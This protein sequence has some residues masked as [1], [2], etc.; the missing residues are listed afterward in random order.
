MS[1]L[2]YI[3]W[4]VHSMQHVCRYAWYQCSNML[5]HS[6]FEKIQKMN[7]KGARIEYPPLKKEKV[8]KGVE[9]HVICVAKCV[10]KIYFLYFC[11]H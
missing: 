5:E 10:H 4:L 1:L 11:N 8:G 9:R 6:H 2:A 7:M 3:Y